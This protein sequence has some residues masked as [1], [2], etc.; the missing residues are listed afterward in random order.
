MNI[1]NLELKKRNSGLSELFQLLAG[2]C[3]AVFL[4]HH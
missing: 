2:L 1:A 4:L 3:L